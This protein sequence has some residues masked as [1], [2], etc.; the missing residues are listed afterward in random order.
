MDRPTGGSSPLVFAVAL[1]LGAASIHAFGEFAY[2]RRW[3]ELGSDETALRAAVAVLLL[4]RSCLAVGVLAVGLV[5][6]SRVASDRTVRLASVIGTLGLFGSLLADLE[7][8][9]RTGNPISIYLPFLFEAETFVWAGTAFDPASAILRFLGQLLGGLVGA[10]VFAWGFERWVEGAPTRR[11]RL[12][13]AL[14]A[15]FLVAVPALAMGAAGSAPA[16]LVAELRD[17]LPSLRRLTFLSTPDA[18][19]GASRSAIAARYRAALPLLS[20]APEW[21]SVPAIDGGREADVLLVVVESLRADA[22][23]AETMP[24]LF[25]WS[26][27]GLSLRRHSSTSNASH[28][29]LFSLLYGR[30]PLRYFETL[31]SG[32]PPTL[33]EALGRSGFSRHVL[34]CAALDWH[35]MDRFMGPPHFELERLRGPDLATCD[36][37]VI[38]RTAALLAPGNRPPRL[39]LAF[40]MSTHFGFHYPEDAAPFQPALG[41]PNAS[42]LDPDRDYEGLHNRYRNSAHYVDALLRSL[43][44]RVDP[45]RT[46]LVVTGDH[47]EALYD[48]GTLAHASRLSD[49][50]T[51]V[52][53]VLTGPDVAAGRVR[54]TPTDHA[55]VARTLLA[56]LG[57]STSSLEGLGG[58]DLV[59][60]PDREFVPV[61]HAKAR[62]GGED[63]LALVTRDA[64]YSLLL[65]GERGFARFGGALGAAGRL[66]RRTVSDAERARVV[67]FFD[68]YLSTFSSRAIR[69]RTSIE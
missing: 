2:F 25:G 14:L 37:R 40:L 39:V 64:R 58:V 23:D 55:D 47:G 27:R 48:D 69:P 62:R 8:R 45:A 66:E 24:F 31:E 9:R 30:S 11:G 56:R 10:S 6:I 50:Q 26:D 21:A 13:V 63:R 36:Q 33:V 3:L 29:G 20:A 4:A 44:E 35:G 67:R 52:P 16:P 19:A 68:D 34:T 32:E 17:Q 51:R 46:L 1:P 15:G 60:G 12:A 49:A 57:A 41:S 53:F 7:I 42:T 28:Y 22:L 38:E 59:D 18:E 61:V 65:D 43:V 54:D 5:A